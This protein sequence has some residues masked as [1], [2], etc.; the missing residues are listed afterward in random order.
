MPRFQHLLSSFLLAPS[1]SSSLV[2]QSLVLILIHFSTPHQNHLS[3]Y[4]LSHII[5]L[6]K[7]VGFLFL[8]YPFLSPALWKLCTLTLQICIEAINQPLAHRLRGSAPSEAYLMDAQRFTESTWPSRS[9]TSWSS[10]TSHTPDHTPALITAYHPLFSKHR[11]LRALTLLLQLPTERSCKTSP[12]TDVSLLLLE[13]TTDSFHHT[14]TH[15]QQWAHC[16]SLSV[17]PALAG[18]H[19]IIFSFVSPLPVPVNNPGPPHVVYSKMAPISLFTKTDAQW[20]VTL[21]SLWAS[22]RCIYLPFPSLLI[23]IWII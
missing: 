23:F 1:E 15:S 16:L 18:R 10:L 22:L 6:L 13:W 20:F 12:L 8:F 5:H 2:F 3:G 14:R 9:L 17:L 11:A 19:G 7:A 21:H 4:H